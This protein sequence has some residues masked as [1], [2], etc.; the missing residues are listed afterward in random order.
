[1]LYQ[2]Y[3]TVQGIDWHINNVQVALYDYIKSKW[4]LPDDSY[5][6]CYARVYRNNTTDGYIAEAFIGGIDYKE[7][8]LDDTKTVLSFFGYESGELSND[9]S[10]TATVTL[11]FFV[12]LS[13]VMTCVNNALANNTFDSVFDLSFSQPITDRE[14]EMVR[15]TVKEF[16]DNSFGFS[17]KKTSI[18]T[19]KVLADYTGTRRKMLDNKYPDMHPWHCFRLD[20]QL[21]YPEGQQ[22]DIVPITTF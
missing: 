13:G 21:V 15:S 17:L 11:I 16:I 14:D 1:M 7:V 5:Y 12:N 9:G 10:Y 22:C 8:F 20:L 6:D 2:R 19:D 18:G 4:A 3:G